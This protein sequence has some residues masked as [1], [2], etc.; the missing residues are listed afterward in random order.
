[1]MRPSPDAAISGRDRT[2]R[3]IEAYGVVAVIRLKEPDKLRGVVDALA[4]GGVRALEITMTGPRAIEL[5]AEIAPTLPD[6]FL[7]GAG[8]VLDAET[9]HRA[10][11]AG[12]QFLVSPVFRPELIAAAH[13]CEV[14]VMPGCFTPTEILTAWDAG[15]DVVKV[16]PA[17]VLGPGF[18]KDVRAPLPQ[19]KL[20]PTGGVTVDNAGDWI[21]AGAVAVGVGS[22]LLD[23]KSIS[24][25]S[26]APIADNA[27]R[28]VANVRAARGQS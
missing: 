27:R 10:V 13:A 17:T 18:F 3:A 6:G 5:I 8:T 24:S 25:G 15:A 20:M 11:D 16:F 19:V 2:T 21:R 1:M 14:P 22:A 26:Y 9:A 23:A 28:I 4:D 12:A 7:L